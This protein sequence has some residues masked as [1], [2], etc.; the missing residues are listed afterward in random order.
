LFKGAGTSFTVFNPATQSLTAAELQQGVELA[1]EALDIVRDSAVWDGTV[2]LTLRVTATGVD[3]SDTVKLRVSPVM[4]FHHLSDVDTLYASEVPYD[5][6][7][8]IFRRDLQT[9]LT[10]SGITRPLAAI[11]TYDQWTQDFFETGYM[12]MPAPG[13]QKVI[14]VNFRSANVQSYGSFPLREASRVVFTGMR[15][16]DVAGVQQYDPRYDPSGEM[17]SLDSFG[18]TETIPPYTFNGVSYPMG[19]ILRGSI[20]SFAPDPSFTRMLESQRVQPLVNVD[21]SWL[22]VGH[23]DETI[24]FIRANNA[25]GWVALVND[26]RL[27]RTMLQ[28]ANN[29]G[30][31]SVKLFTG[32]QWLDD[33]N[34]PYSAE[35]TIRQV[36]A[37]TEVMAESANTAAHIDRQVAILKAATGL[38]DAEIVRVPYLHWPVSGLSLAYQPGTVNGVVANGYR[39]YTPN[40]HGPVI[41]GKDLFKDQLERALQPYGVT[42]HYVEDWNLYH[43]LAGEV[44]CGSNAARAIP[45]AKWWES[46]R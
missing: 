34:R 41:N 4:L 25:R 39:F 42:V 6:D 14:R 40:P 29:A 32:K 18:N 23:V 11:R 26:P 15:G 27:A 12:S 10:A 46:G 20:P 24:S 30:H 7:S 33:Y 43:R 21:T 17:D 37:D 19:R 31:G 16:K 9:A 3:A 44:H 22:L 35:V 36:L 8:A 2:S 13:G 38:T 5:N 45:S 28:N 1:I